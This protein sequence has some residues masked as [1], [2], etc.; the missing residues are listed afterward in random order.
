MLNY[1]YFTGKLTIKPETLWQ[2][3]TNI[4]EI[5]L[6]LNES[7]HTSAINLLFYLRPGKHEVT[8]REGI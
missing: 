2:N 1:Y 5:M 4:N 7:P 8:H 3:K 6:I